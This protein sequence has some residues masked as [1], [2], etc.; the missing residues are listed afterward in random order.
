MIGRTIPLVCPST[1]RSASAEAHPARAGPPQLGTL[2]ASPAGLG[3][4]EGNELP[5]QPSALARKKKNFE[6]RWTADPEAKCYLP[7]VPRAT[8]M[9]FPFQIIQGS[10]S[11]MIVYEFAAAARMPAS[12][13][14]AVFA[15]GATTAGKVAAST[16]GSFAV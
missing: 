14:S 2:L 5:Y 12:R 8:Y 13:A 16:S 11:I 1:L 10:D 9:P 6:T 7:G 15:P 3:V 4:V